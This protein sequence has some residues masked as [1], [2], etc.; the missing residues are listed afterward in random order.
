MLMPVDRTGDNPLW[1]DGEPYYDDFYAIWDTYRTSSP[2]I[3]LIDPDRQTDIVRALVNIY[4]RDGYMPDAR[5]GN[6]NGRTQGRLERRNRGG[7]R[8]REGAAGHRLRTGAAGHA[9]GRHRAPRRQ[10]GGRGP[11]RARALPATG[12]HSPRR[13]KG[14]QPHGG[15]FLLRLRHR[16]RGT[17]TG[18]RQPRGEIPP[19]VGQLEE[20]VA[21]GLRARRGARFHH[22]ARRRGAM[23][24]RPA[25]RAL[26]PAAP[27][28]SLH[29]AD[30]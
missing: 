8:L 15:I 28:L 20:P 1:T 10:R 17:R 4:K 14:R 27:H 13:G 9:Q 11:G 16:H 21:R 26:T 2:L 7:R 18:T 30:H 24:R 3:T 25:L 19:P 22:A 6:C 29:A 5:S 23:A 12:L